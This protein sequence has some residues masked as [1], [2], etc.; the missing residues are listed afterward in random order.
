MAVSLLQNLVHTL[1]RKPLDGVPSLDPAQQRR[2]VLMAARHA[3]SD[4]L[5]AFRKRLLTF[6][7]LDN[8]IRENAW[9]VIALFWVIVPLLALDEVIPAVRM[10]KAIEEHWQAWL[11]SSDPDLD[12]WVLE[13][14]VRRQIKALSWKQR[15][16][17]KG[18]ERELQKMSRHGDK[19][20]AQAEKVGQQ[21]ASLPPDALAARRAGLETRRDQEADP[22]TA[23]G[24]TRQIQAIDGQLE[25]RKLL[26]A[27]HR[28]L[29][30]GLE[31][32]LEV[33]RHLSTR[34]AVLSTNKAEARKVEADQACD[35]LRAVVGQL[36]AV[37][38]A[39]EELQV[40]G[41]R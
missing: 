37:Q 25:G 3:A 30:S 27:R 18:L 11:D 17:L 34:L 5:P 36:A 9:V 20:S 8:D 7:E 32:E 41:R 4:R 13:G 15:R 1:A 38:Q 28:R 6:E 14:E 19:I 2:L 21:L 29:L 33:L 12:R 35:E 23:A 39:E 10:R 26:E 40:V 31:E 22:A 24:L 16:T